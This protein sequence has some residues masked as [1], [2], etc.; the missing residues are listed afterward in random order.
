MDLESFYPAKDRFDLA[1]RLNNLLAAPG[2]EAWTEGE[3]LDAGKL[4]YTAS[5][6]PRVSVLSIAHL[7]DAERMF[8]VTLLLNEVIAWMRAQPG[9]ASLRAI[10]YMDEVFGY[11]PPVANPASKQL[12]LTLLKQARA[13]RP[14]HRARHAESGRPRLQGAVE[15]G[16]LV[17]RPA[18]DRT[19]P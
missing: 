16:H 15:C 1:M 17:D 19:G 2:F 14:R 11:L 4:L 9:T 13:Y 5:G 7:N 6:Q 18:A 8:F 10:L 3:P 12:L